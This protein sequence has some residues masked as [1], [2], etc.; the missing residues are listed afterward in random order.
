LV[1]N[2]TVVPSEILTQD[3]PLASVIDAYKAFD[4][5]RPGWIKVKIE[6]PSSRELAA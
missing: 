2:G 5:R 6:P 3:E 4:K 1:R